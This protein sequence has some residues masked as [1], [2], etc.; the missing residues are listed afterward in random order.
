MYSSTQA[1]TWCCW[2]TSP[3]MAPPTHST[4]GICPG[5]GGALSPLKTRWSIPKVSVVSSYTPDYREGSWFILTEG[6]EMSLCTKQKNNAKHKMCL[7]DRPNKVIF[8]FLSWKR[9][10]CSSPRRGTQISRLLRVLF[11]KGHRERRQTHPVWGGSGSAGGTVYHQSCTQTQIP[12]RPETEAG[13]YWW[14]D[15]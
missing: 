11:G 3:Q 2:I 14:R 12:G 5:R 7:S 1:R 4:M 9:I 6:L 13:E 8:F 15:R 10:L